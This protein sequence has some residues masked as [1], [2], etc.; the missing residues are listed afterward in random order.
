[1][2]VYYFSKLLFMKHLKKILRMCGLIF[3]ILLAVSG[4]GIIGAAPLLN[5][6]NELFADKI[7]L[8]EE[9]RA[10]K[11]EWEKLKS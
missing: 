3:F 8:V 7:E 11:G 5:K 6:D 9:N 4:V 2:Q 10:K 1:M